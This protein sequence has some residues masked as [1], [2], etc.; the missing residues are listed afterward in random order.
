MKKEERIIVSES[1]K[2]R[3]GVTES[4][5]GRRKGA[6]RKPSGNV[7]FEAWVKPATKSAIAK[8]TAEKSLRHPGELLDAKFIV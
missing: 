6:G 2:T 4:R 1:K 5:G 8:Q 3:S 7:R